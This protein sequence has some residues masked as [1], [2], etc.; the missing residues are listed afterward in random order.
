MGVGA[1]VAEGYQ[2]GEC[3][4]AFGAADQ[5]CGARLVLG[6]GRLGETCPTNG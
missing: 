5:G 2:L 6:E 3:V 4:R 1:A